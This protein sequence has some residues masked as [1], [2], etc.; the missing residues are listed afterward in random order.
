MSSDSKFAMEEKQESVLH[1]A[2]GLDSQQETWEAIHKSA[3]RGV[4]TNAVTD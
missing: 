2:T 1:A 4:T 3:T